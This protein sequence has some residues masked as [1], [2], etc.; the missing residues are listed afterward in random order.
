MPLNLQ[1]ALRPLAHGIKD[2]ARLLNAIKTELL[3]SV[4]VVKR[5]V[6]GKCT[7]TVEKRVF[8]VG[9]TSKART[10]NR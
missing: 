4:P 1:P 2:N 10:L 9:C 7:G 5:Q 6:C 8:C 3:M